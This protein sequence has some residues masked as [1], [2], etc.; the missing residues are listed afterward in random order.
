MRQIVP[1]GEDRVGSEKK[2]FV[3][4]RGQGLKQVRALCE[5]KKTGSEAS[6]RTL[7]GGREKSETI[8]RTVWGREDNF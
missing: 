6:G 8:G 5:D 1:S 7:R 3:S 4:I 2:Y